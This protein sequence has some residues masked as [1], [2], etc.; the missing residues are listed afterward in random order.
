[1]RKCVTNG[2]KCD[3]INQIRSMGECSMGV[4][5]SSVPQAY[6]PV[7]IGIL[8]FTVVLTVVLFFVFKKVSDK[9]LL[10][11]I[12]ILGALMILA[13]IWKQFFV[14]KYVY[15]GEKSNW[16]CPWQL[17][18]MAMYCSFSLI[19]LKGKA[20]ETVLV[21]LSTFTILAAVMALAAP[22]DMLRPQIALFCHSFLYHIIMLVEAF[23]A[24]RILLRREKVRFWPSAVLFLA[25]ASVA[26]VINIISHRV[27][28]EIRVEANMFYI[29]PYYPTTQP[30]L[31]SIAARIGT[32]PYIFLYLLGIILISFGIFALEF[33]TRR[34]KK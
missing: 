11:L 14:V 9:K 6:G 30:V 24:M 27:I 4:Q 26:E 32:V 29:T 2:V 15:A 31:H 33:K 12:I 13:E 18:S 1:M 23:A 19:F 22:G 34:K 5:F 25:L 3:K 21:F 10:R 28:G 20:Q 7:H 17:C 8:V 16:F